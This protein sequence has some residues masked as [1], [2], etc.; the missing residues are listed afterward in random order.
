MREDLQKLLEI[1]VKLSIDA[2]RTILRIYEGDFSVQRKSDDSPLTLADIN[3]HR[4]ISE[5]LSISGIPLLS[6]EGK[7]IPYEMRKGW[8]YLWLVDPLDGTKEFINKNGEFTVNIALIH[9]SR[10][11]L[12]VIYA[13]AQRLLY[14]ALKGKGAFKVLLHDEENITDIISHSI[15]L[16][17]YE[18]NNH[19]SIRIIASRSHLSTETKQYINKLQ[20]KY[21]DVSYLSAGSSLKFCLIAEGKA[22]I[23]PRFGPTMEWDTAAG[24]IIVQE[25]GGEVFDAE[26]GKPLKYN[27]E[28]LNNLYFIVRGARFKKVDKENLNEKPQCYMASKAYK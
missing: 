27:K 15:K 8:E 3:S 16:P 11:I 26:T 23:Y 1:S 12:G 17:L 22:D 19:S 10:P 25:A 21:R 14:Y 18:H 7:G 2:G 20:D 28:S 4:I 24:E 13:P 5:G 9:N 6:E